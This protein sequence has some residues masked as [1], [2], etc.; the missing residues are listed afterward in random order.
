MREI[1]DLFFAAGRIN[2]IWRGVFR[3]LQSNYSTTTNRKLLCCVKGV[4]RTYKIRRMSVV[5]IP[6]NRLFRTLCIGET[7]N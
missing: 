1:D 2:N 3:M 7:L 5:K 4:I 6:K